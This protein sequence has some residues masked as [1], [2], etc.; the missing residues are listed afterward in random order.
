MHLQGG[1]TFFGREQKTM[2]VLIKWSL[3]AVGALWTYVEPT[4]P[5]ALICVLAV[6]VDCVSAWRLS[7]RVKKAYPDGGADGKFKSAHAMKMMGNIGMAFAC[8]VMASMV[9]TVILP[10]LDLMLGNY[11]AAIFCFVEF[12]SILENESSCNGA[13]WAKLLQRIMVDK[14]KRHLDVDFDVEPKKE[15]NGEH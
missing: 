13:P 3:S 14:T 9:D 12:W 2:K 5:F 10:H 6:L 11:V 15:E 7:Q 4:I 1:E 8:M